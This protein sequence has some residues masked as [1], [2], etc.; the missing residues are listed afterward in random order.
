MQACADKKKNAC[1]ALT[2]MQENFS[3]ASRPRRRHRLAELIKEI[4]EQQME[5]E[6]E[7]LLQANRHNS[8]PR[9]LVLT[10]SLLAVLGFD[11]CFASAP[12]CGQRLFLFSRFFAENPEGRRDNVGILALE[13]HQVAGN[14]VAGVLFQSKVNTVLL[15]GGGKGPDVLVGDLDVGNAGVVFHNLSEGL[16]AVV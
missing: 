15:G 6:D 11:R 12:F 9:S 3:E 4:H 13:E 14:L 2:Q 7:S 16:L 1:K 5:V 10:F 8:T